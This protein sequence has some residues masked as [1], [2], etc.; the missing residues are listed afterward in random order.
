MPKLTI[1]GQSV[2]IA[3]GATI[4]ETAQSLGIEVPTRCPRAGLPHYTSCLLCVVEETTSGKLLPSCAALAHDGMV[5]ETRNGAVEESRRMAL[6]LLLSEH[7]GDCDA[8]CRR[9]C[10]AHMN[11]PLMIRQIG[12]GEMREAIMTVKRHIALPAVLGRI[13][14]APCER[15]CKH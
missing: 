9:A 10:P 6:D 2:E 12:R 7:V 14:P 5:I 3:P 4:L 8:P 1:D 11:I 15:A 13:C